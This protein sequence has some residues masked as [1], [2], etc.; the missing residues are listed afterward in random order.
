MSWLSPGA[1]WWLLLIPALLALYLFRP[2]SLRKPVPSLR[3]WDKLPQVDRPRARL[4]RPP[5]SLLLLLQLLL[6]VA[7]TVALIRPA[8]ET[9]VG[10]QYVILL[11]A[12]GSMAATSG[13]TTR[14]EQAKVEARQVASQ[15]RAQDRATL[16][17]VGSS[18]TTAC[19][20]CERANVESAI[21]AMRAGAGQADMASA[22][23]LA[24][25]LAAGAPDG[26]VQTYVISDGGFPQ[27]PNSKF[28]I[29]NSKFVQVGEPVGNRAVTVLSARRPPDGRPGY[30]AYARVD[31]AGTSEATVQVAALADTVPLADRNVTLAPGGHADFTW[32]LPAG[33][34]RFTV[35]LDGHDAIGADDS[36][37]IFLPSEGQYKVSIIVPQPDLYRRVLSGIPGLEPVVVTTENPTPPGSVAFTIIQGRVPDPLPL[38]S[39]LLVNPAGDLFP[40]KGELEDLRSI[41]GGS[42]HPVMSGL[43]LS[44]LLVNNARQIDVPSWLEPIAWSDARTP[45]IVAGEHE[46]KRM[47]ALLFDPDDSNLPKLAAFPLLMANVVDWLFPLASAGAISPG[48]PIYLAPG[49]TL[50]TPSGQRLQ[51]G[52]SGIF[53]ETEEAG[54]Y[55]LA[56]D[57][58][59][60]VRFSVN[61]AS[62]SESTTN[63]SPHPEL[64][65]PKSKTAS[66]TSPKSE[67]QEIWASLAGVALFLVGGEW[68][69]YCWKRGRL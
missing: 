50:T 21:L 55:Q 13:N 8:L 23:S 64:D 28:K 56:G 15:M 35:N 22:L 44:P 63:P 9:P 14:F 45:L 43:D 38:G 29:Q 17:R 16:V 25:G 66:G 52:P 36:A 24:S 11:D 37:V 40:A 59:Q 34:V 41:T 42:T 39:L 20:N 47:A 69:Y 33:T 60:Q 49:S 6:L 67:N 2:R 27:D 26:N 65:N 53:N 5:L 4:R 3:L 46:G 51:V 31:N 12:S 68:L 54:V 62:L 61:M 57:A 10:Q 18:V 7:G 32:Q 1:A 30:V 19:A 48:D 58:P